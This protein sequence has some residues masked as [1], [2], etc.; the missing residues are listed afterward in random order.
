MEENRLANTSHGNAVT[1]ER[2]RKGDRIAIVSPATIV[3]EEYVAGAVALMRRQGFDPVVMPS[4]L[5]PAHGSYAASLEA[6]VA[7]LRNALTDKS[8]KC[9]FCARGGYGCVHLLPYISFEHV[10]KNPKWLVGFS[11][12]SALHA[13]WLKSGVKSIHGPM[14]KHLTLRRDDE[15]TK[16]LLGILEGRQT[17]DYAVAPH[18]LNRC[19]HAEGILRGGNLAVLNSL[20]ATPYDILSIET[21]E[22]VVLFIEDISEAIYAVERMLMRL[23]LAGVLG[24]IKGLIVGQ[25]TEYRPGRNFSNMNEMISALLER[26]HIAGIPVAF[27]F[28]TGHVDYNLPLIEGERVAFS[29]GPDK[30]SL[31]SIAH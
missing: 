28:P 14:A 3:K 12:I 6:R 29:V 9:I 10:S 23:Y 25:F 31:V 13:L 18:G 8:V 7:D 11:D 24:K 26:C 17:L 2:L 20:A 16:A 30:V 1:P 27:N 21:G 15:S 19:G 22:D 4:A 5:G